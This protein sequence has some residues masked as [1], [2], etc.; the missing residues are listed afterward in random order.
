MTS[1]EVLDVHCHFVPPATRE[2]LAS[3]PSVTLTDRGV[4]R[5]PAVLPLPA[6][7]SDWDGLNAHRTG[8]AGAVVAPP[9][10]LY[11]EDVAAGNR[12]YVREVN[13]A[14]AD[15]ARGRE[16]LAALAW[17]PLSSPE[18]A[19]TEVARVAAD[20]LVAGVVVSTSLGTA[21]A[22]PSLAA[23][24][25]AL[26]EAGL[27]VFVHPDSDPFDPCCRP[28]PGPSV[29]GFPAAT[30]AVALVLL[31]RAESLWSAGVKV[32]LSHGGGFLATALGRVRRSDPDL[33]ALVRDRLRQV[34]VDS[35]VF[36][37]GLL[38]L[39]AATFGPER[40]LSGSD[41]PF[42]LSMSAGEL[43]AQ[44][45]HVAGSPAMWCSRLARLASGVSP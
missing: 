16:G 31:A 30:T 22:D 2:F 21:I 23:V 33:D 45:E 25:S 35:V 40:T 15:L 7:L 28:L 18:A 6:R 12:D 5:G 9:P 24:W 11:L 3:V 1:W 36:G 19:L 8:L 32:C 44:R 29:F 14:L 43:I 42:P 13:G 41:W 37:D 17:L 26:A 4:V 20:P 10:A 39:V 27:G 34:W 38:E